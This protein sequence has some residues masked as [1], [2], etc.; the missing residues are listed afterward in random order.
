MARRGRRVDLHTYLLS[1]DEPPHFML[2]DQIAS[3]LKDAMRARDK[4]RLRTLRSISAAL[5][6]MEIDEGD[7]SEQQ[8]LALL[9]KQA[10]QRQEAIEQYDDA[11]RDDLADKEREELA[12]IEEYLPQPLDDDELE[13]RLQAIIDEVGASSMADMGP[14]MGK[15]MEQLRGRADGNR[16]RKAVQNLLSN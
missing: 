14:V 2:K 7:L 15:A 10:K 3:D 6:N 12:V 5:R 8:E 4:V 1:F 13:A 16:V 9:R 11:G